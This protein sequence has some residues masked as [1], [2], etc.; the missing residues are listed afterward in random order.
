MICEPMKKLSLAASFALIVI[1]FTGC[2]D[3]MKGQNVNKANFEHVAIN[4][5]DPVAMADWYCENLGMKVVFKGDPPANTRFVSDADGNMMFEL[6]NNSSV[7]VPD[8]AA[9]DM[10]VLHFAFN[11]DNVKETC[12]R[13]VKAGAKWDKEFS[14]SASGDEIATLR[15][16]WGLAI[17]FVKRAKPMI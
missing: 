16:P 11:V 7:P 6:Y 4:V 15:D 3:L 14:V 2:T 8:Y 9:Q 17:Q 1:V 13:L 12:E 10:L 5:K